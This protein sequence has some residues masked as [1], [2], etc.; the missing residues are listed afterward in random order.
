MPAISWRLTDARGVRVARAAG[1]GA[2]VADGHALTKP[3]VERRID[4][5]GGG[6]VF[7]QQRAALVADE[8]GELCAGAQRSAAR[9]SARWRGLAAVVALRRLRLH[10]ALDALVVGE[11]T[12]VR[13]RRGLDGILRVGGR[14]ASAD[15]PQSTRNMS[16]VAVKRGFR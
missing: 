2:E 14:C 5:G 16:D 4:V 10:G 13:M 9:V 7:P 1:L 15:L 11:R 3:R 6:H 12:E 8:R